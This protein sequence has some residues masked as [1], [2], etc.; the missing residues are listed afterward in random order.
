MMKLLACTVMA[1]AA[2]AAAVA[3]NTFDNEACSCSGAF[4]N[5][6]FNSGVNDQPDIV[7]RFQTLQSYGVS[8]WG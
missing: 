6:V 3:S 5:V 4:K 2:A 8:M 7:G 1:C